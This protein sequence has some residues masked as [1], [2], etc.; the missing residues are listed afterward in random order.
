MK[1]DIT[2]DPID[3]KRIIKEYY[4][5]LYAH[6]VHNLDEMDQF[7]ERYNLPKIIQEEIDD[8]NRLIFTKESESIINNPPEQKALG[9]EGFTGEFYQT[10]EDETITT[11]YKP[12]IYHHLPTIEAKGIFPDSFYEASITRKPQ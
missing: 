2:T 8:L 3:I 6:I 10:F 7:F 4:K 5:Q 12:I 11:I 1:G 9:P